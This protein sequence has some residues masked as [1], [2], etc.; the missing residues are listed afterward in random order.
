[1]KSGNPDI[2]SDSFNF[3]LVKISMNF[4][5]EIIIISR[6]F[7]FILYFQITARKNSK[8]VMNLILRIIAMM[9]HGELRI[10]KICFNSI[11]D[12]VP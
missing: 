5:H 3:Y 6:L 4:M 7:S 9:T 8:S 1:M 2:Y 11:Y 10:Q 12:M